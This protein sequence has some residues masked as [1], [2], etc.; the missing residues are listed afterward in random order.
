MLDKVSSEDSTT[1]ALAKCPCR[2]A[3]H[4]KY[5]D[6]CIFLGDIAKSWLKFR[7]SET[8]LISLKEAREV[9]QKAQQ[10]KLISC[11]YICSSNR[12]YS[13]CNC[14]PWDCLGLHLEV[15]H[16]IEMGVLPGIYLAYIKDNCRVNDGC[17]QECKK[18]CYFKAIT[19]G[20]SQMV[21]NESRCHGCGLCYENCPYGA[22]ELRKERERILNWYFPYGL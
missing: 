8:R 10:K 19:P 5:E 9:L 22:V 17:A 4:N 7:Q 11:P 2:I 1:I 3:M 16:G 6:W 12:L 20:E 15:M 21:V 14:D 18:Y 13:I